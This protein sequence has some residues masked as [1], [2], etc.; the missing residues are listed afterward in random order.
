[1][2][3]RTTLLLLI[4]I[5]IAAILAGILVG[6]LK[7]GTTVDFT[8]NGVIPGDSIPP[9]DMSAPAQI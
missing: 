5:L 4:A 7:E 8:K 2:N 9:I 3:K 1:L 6:C